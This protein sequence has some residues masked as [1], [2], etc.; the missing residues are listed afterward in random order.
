MQGR[1]IQANYKYDIFRI[2]AKEHE[3]DEKRRVVNQMKTEKK[4]K[5]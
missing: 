1:E 3:G 2:K 4:S 5:K